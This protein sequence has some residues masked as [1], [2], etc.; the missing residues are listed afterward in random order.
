MHRIDSVNARPNQNGAGK[1]GFNDNTDISGMDATY[2]T[3]E[4]CNA[5][6]EELANVIAAAG[7][8]LNKAQ[9]NQLLAGIRNLF[10]TYTDGEI[11][12]LT[13][14][15]DTAL[16]NEAV[17]RLAADTGEANI[18]WTADNGLQLQLNNLVG[19]CNSLQAQ[20]DALTSS[21]WTAQQIFDVAHPVGSITLYNVNPDLAAYNSTGVA[22]TWTD[23]GKVYDAD[24]RFAHRNT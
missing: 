11:A 18:R 14:A 17:V 20:I 15:L 5:I 9:N 10:Q 12:A 19:V 21:N 7:I 3:P 23:G 4:W 8:V 6:Q 22:S 1:D 16:A 2:Q 13:A 24:S